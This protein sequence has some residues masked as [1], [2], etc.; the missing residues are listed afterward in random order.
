MAHEEMPVSRETSLHAAG[1]YFKCP[2]TQ[3][4]TQTLLKGSVG[5]PRRLPVQP[6]RPRPRAALARRQRR[7]SGGSAR[8]LLPF[9]ASRPQLHPP[10]A[11]FA[12]C[13][14]SGKSPGEGPR[15]GDKRPRCPHAAGGQQ[16]RPPRPLAPLS[17][18]PP[19]HRPRS[20]TR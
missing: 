14:G 18:A 1:M 5:D 12:G 6:Q 9:C 4:P 11:P 17:P 13:Q 15:R 20:D 3:L 8:L 10:G 7:R 2:N 16:R 19:P